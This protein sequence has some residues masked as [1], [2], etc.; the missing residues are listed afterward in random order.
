MGLLILLLMS[1]AFW[2]VSA[3]TMAAIETYVDHFGLRVL[4]MLVAALTIGALAAAFDYPYFLV[5]IPL[6]Y[7]VWMLR[8]RLVDRIR[9]TPRASRKYVFP[10]L[11]FVVVATGSALTLAAETCDR[12]GHCRAMFIEKIYR[13]PPL[14]L[15]GEPEQR[16]RL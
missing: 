10:S 7:Q 15:P 1:V 11:L 8:A 14:A 12:R 16:R 13:I 5:A 2:Y 6:A 4:L 9:F 3:M